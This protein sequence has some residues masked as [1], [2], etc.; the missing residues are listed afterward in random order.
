MDVERIKAAI[1][2][3]LEKRE[4]S[5]TEEPGGLLLSQ[6]TKILFKKG[7]GGGWFFA[8]ILIFIIL[9]AILSAIIYQDTNNQLET[10]GIT[11]ARNLL[12]GLVT[13]PIILITLSIGLFFSNDEKYQKQVDSLGIEAEKGLSGLFG[14]QYSENATTFKTKDP[15]EMKL[16]LYAYRLGGMPKDTRNF[17]VDTGEEVGTIINR[18]IREYSNKDVKLKNAMIQIGK[19]DNGVELHRDF[20]FWTATAILPFFLIPIMSLTLYVMSISMDAQTL[21]LLSSVAATLSI[22]ALLN[23]GHY[24]LYNIFHDLSKKRIAEWFEKSLLKDLTR[25]EYMEL[26]RAF[27]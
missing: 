26:I 23:F 24:V 16:W 3:I 1:T 17:N 19:F 20:G 7:L 18:S 12:L 13:G 15:S 25:D 2:S 5:E 8:L 11:I 6:R 27:D 9:E 10:S 4:L 22:I 14:V 21:L